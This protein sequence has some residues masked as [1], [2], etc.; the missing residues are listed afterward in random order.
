MSYCKS[1]KT[2]AES[3]RCHW[4][5]LLLGR[6]NGIIQQEDIPE[7][8]IHN[9]LLQ[10]VFSAF[11]TNFYHHSLFRWHVL[12]E[13]SAV[14]VVLSYS[15]LCHLILFCDIYWYLKLSCAILSYHMLSY[16]N[17]CYPLIFCGIFGYLV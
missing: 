7:M 11:P 9:F 8:L 14:D 13:R 5:V 3:A 12:G 4:E 1:G 6:W 2:Y 15:I 16:A 17:L 10:A